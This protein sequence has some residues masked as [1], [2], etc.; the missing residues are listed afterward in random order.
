MFDGMRPILRHRNKKMRC[1]VSLANLLLLVAICF[2]ILTRCSPNLTRRF[3]YD[4]IVLLCVTQS[5]CIV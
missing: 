2:N 1:D 3:A 4:S 5:D